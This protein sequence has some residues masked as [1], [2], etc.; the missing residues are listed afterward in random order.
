MI[1]YDTESTARRIMLVCSHVRGLMPDENQLQTATAF[2][3]LRRID[4]MIEQYAKESLSFYVDNKERL[5]DER[6]DAKLRE[7]SGGY[8]FYNYSGYT[9]EGILLSNNSI[10]VVMNSYLKKNN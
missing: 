9:F 8:P 4:C 7:I 3:F 10:D 5:S 6:L 2:T 1:I